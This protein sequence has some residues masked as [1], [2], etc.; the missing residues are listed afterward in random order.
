MQGA[1][2]ED[3]AP[4]VRT[5]PRHASVPAAPSAGYPRTVE[6]LATTDVALRLALLSGDED[7][8]ASVLELI[9]SA[10]RDRLRL[11][12]VEAYLDALLDGGGDALP[13]AARL[14]RLLG[15]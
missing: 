12:L 4:R 11:R 3:A 8:A 10:D 14:R 2:P 13:G 15:D 5:S 1:A 6:G 9:R 7:L